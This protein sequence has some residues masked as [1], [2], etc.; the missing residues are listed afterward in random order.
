MKFFVTAQ[1]DIRAC[2]RICYF[3]FVIKRLC[4]SNFLR[5]SHRFSL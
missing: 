4:F 1:P 2:A 5:P 3:H